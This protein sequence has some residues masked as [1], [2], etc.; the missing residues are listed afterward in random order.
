MWRWDKID[1]CPRRIAARSRWPSTGLS[2][3]PRE[4]ADMGLQA[5]QNVPMTWRYS[6]AQGLDIGGAIPL[7][8]EQSLLRA[9]AP[10]T[11][12]QQRC[13]ER[14]R[15]KSCLHVASPF[16]LMMTNTLLIA[17]PF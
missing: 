17:S 9:R 2:N 7:R 15:S 10:R 8:G 13:T 3:S 5:S 1:E 12:K 6:R 4:F 16:S 14:D 11:G